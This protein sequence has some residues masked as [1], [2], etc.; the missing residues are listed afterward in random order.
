MAAKTK[1]NLKGNQ[2][3]SY[4]TLVVDFPLASIRSNEHL[5]AA[6]AV[7]DRLLAKGELDQGES[8]YLDALSDL[9]AS[10]EDDH[11]PFAPVSDADML[12]HLLES[13]AI[14]Q[15]DLSRETGVPKST[16]S[17]VLAGKK[18]FSRQMIRKLATFF[19]VDV[20]VLTTNL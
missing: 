7:I 9:V 10:Y 16:I 2:K 19:N 6:Q 15:A 20:S 18:K 1:F 13:K 12:Q 5:Q 11:F 17:E 4:L 14:A 8:L 3:D